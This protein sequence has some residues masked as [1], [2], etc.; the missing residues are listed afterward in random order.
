M[1]PPTLF[2]PGCGDREVGARLE[3]DP[4]EAS[5]VRA[6]RLHP[7]DEVE[8]TDG[9][10]SLWRARVETAEGSDAACTL[11][12]RAEPPPV[13]PVD[14]AFGVAKKDRT[15]WL[16]EKAVELGVRSLAPVEV[17][18]SRSVADGARSRGFWRK[19]ERRAVAALKQ[20]GG[21][22][23]P[24]ILPVRDL[25]EFMDGLEP[26]RP[27][28]PAEEEGAAGAGPAGD[29][30]RGWGGAVGS[31][32]RRYLARGDAARTLLEAETAR[33]EPGPTRLLVGPEG[34]LEAGEV[35]ACL[36]AGFDPVRLGPGT[37]RFE[38]AA[39]AAVAVL[40][41]AWELRDGP[42]AGRSEGDRRDRE[43]DGGTPGDPS[44]KAHREGRSR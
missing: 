17:A 6:L 44:E 3:L 5:H 39:V 15:L 9:R 24:G 34:G 20:C 14:L 11:L 43:V 30:G 4:D 27:G 32:G 7:G 29:G 40:V 1:S 36:R 10:G 8:V 26:G 37:L 2:A 23:L 13:A 18:R 41:Q 22:R 16:V 12:E 33:V 19:A 35:Q 25:A 21:A 28:G 42:S 31:P 38:T